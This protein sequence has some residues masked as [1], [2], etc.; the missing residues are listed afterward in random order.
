MDVTENSQYIKSHGI[1]K[2]KEVSYSQDRNNA[3]WYCLSEEIPLIFRDPQ[4]LEGIAS[5]LEERTLRIWLKLTIKNGRE[6]WECNHSSKSGRSRI[7]GKGSFWQEGRLGGSLIW[8]QLGCHIILVAMNKLATT[9]HFTFFVLFCS[10]VTL[11]TCFLNFR[12]GNLKWQ[13]LSPQDLRESGKELGLGER[14]AASV[15]PHTGGR[16]CWGLEAVAEHK[17]QSFLP[18]PEDGFLWVTLLVLAD[19]LYK[20]NKKHEVFFEDLV[21]NLFNI[22]L[23]MPFM[24]LMKDQNI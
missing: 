3:R 8:Y 17:L 2:A 13:F 15:L 23:K 16:L 24:G 12:H 5:K 1:F 21:D 20:R 4:V 18:G 6:G 11:I 14:E 22:S 7:L 9:A 10:K 19:F